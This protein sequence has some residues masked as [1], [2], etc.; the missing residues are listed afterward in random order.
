ME[1]NWREN[2]RLSATPESKFSG[3]E[4][5]FAAVCIPIQ[6][7]CIAKMITKSKRI[8]I[9]TDRRETLV[10]KVGGEPIR[11]LFCEL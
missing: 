8:L 11:Q 3:T 7:A 10:V 9:Q 5:E 4:T 2:S 6:K 1:T